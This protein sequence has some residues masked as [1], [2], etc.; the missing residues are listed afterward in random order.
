MDI[1]TPQLI[2]I[3]PVLNGFV[4]DLGCQSVVYRTA[5]EVG[6]AVTAYYAN[7][8]AYVRDMLSTWKVNQTLTPEYIASILDTNRCEVGGGVEGCDN[9]RTPRPARGILRGE[10]EGIRPEITH[11][12]ACMPR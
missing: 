8:F 3:R 2:T 10:G 11:A 1:K 7:P 5:A 9:V 4:V 12:N 6:E